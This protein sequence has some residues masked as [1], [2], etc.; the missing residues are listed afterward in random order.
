M[1]IQDLSTN[2]LTTF[3]SL[4]ASRKK[5]EIVVLSADKESCIIILKKDDHIK[6]VSDII[7]DEIKQWKFVQNADYT[8]NELKRF[9]Y[10][11]YLYF[12]KREH[13]QEMRST[14][15]QLVFFATVTMHQFEFISDITQQQFK[16]RPI[17]DQ[18][19][20]YI[21]KASKVVPKYLGRMTK[22][23]YAITDTLRS[24]DSHK[25]AQSDDNYEDVSYNIESLFTSAQVEE[26]IDFIIYKIFVKKELNPF[27]KESQSLKIC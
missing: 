2:V 5:K 9:Q 8:C 11:L 6:K 19:G 13:F 16:L 21:Y 20:T 3:K 14:S 4:N 1:S 17:V 15:N 24:I 27:C 12:F 22:N 18:P 23:D 10:F 25:S 7:E 26:T